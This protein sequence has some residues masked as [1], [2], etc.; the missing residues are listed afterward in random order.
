MLVE[1]LLFADERFERDFEITGNQHL[2]TITVEADELAQEIDRQETLPLLV[3]LLENDLRQN[4]AGDVRRLAYFLIVSGSPDVAIF[5]KLKVFPHPGRIDLF[6][7]ISHRFVANSTRIW[8]EGGLVSARGSGSK[9]ARPRDSS[10]QAPSR[11][12]LGVDAPD[13]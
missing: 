1:L 12:R 7:R 4:R 8:L 6:P 9:F 13:A 10:Q 5:A 2:Q 3:L 11:N